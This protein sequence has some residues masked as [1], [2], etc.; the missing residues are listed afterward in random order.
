MLKPSEYSLNLPFTLKE[1]WRRYRLEKHNQR[2]FSE[3]YKVAFF[4]VIQWVQRMERLESAAVAERA[5]IYENPNHVTK[6]LL[7]FMGMFS[8][9]DYA[10]FTGLSYAKL[11]RVLHGETALTLPELIALASYHGITLNEFDER[12]C[13]LFASNV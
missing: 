13:T 3:Q 6:L 8:L 12:T 10:Q 7:H 9:R 1:S 11:H 2:S 4:V 5:A